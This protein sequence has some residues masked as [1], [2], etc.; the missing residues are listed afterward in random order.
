MKKK[1]LFRLSVHIPLL[2]FFM[3]AFSIMSASTAQSAET[4]NIGFLAALSGPDAGWGLPGLTGNQI[5]I[6]RVNAEGGLNVRQ[7]WQHS[8]CDKKRRLGCCG[9]FHH[10]VLC[11]ALPGIA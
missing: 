2:L 3:V 10:Q 5:F 9:L 1:Q 7:P 4:I 6:D 11:G 8:L